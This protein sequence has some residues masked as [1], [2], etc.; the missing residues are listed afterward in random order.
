MS[1]K[2][3]RQVKELFGASVPVVAESFSPSYYVIGSLMAR[4]APGFQLQ[5]N[6][7]RIYFNDDA[8]HE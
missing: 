3:K 8:D 2:I 4:L 5:V 1:S 6:G 7:D